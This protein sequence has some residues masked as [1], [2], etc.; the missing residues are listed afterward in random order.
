MV[1]GESWVN[2]DREEAAR[3][4]QE[5]ALSWHHAAQG[6]L[7]ATQGNTQQQE[8]SVLGQFR[9]LC[10]KIRELHRHLSV[11]RDQKQC[12]GLICVCVCLK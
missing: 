8:S 11:N 12:L 4:Y 6:S 10:N 5:A 3:E 2:I 1:Q 7:K 9:V